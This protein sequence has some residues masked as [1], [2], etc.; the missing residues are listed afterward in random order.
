MS[1][2]ASSGSVDDYLRR[3]ALTLIGKSSAVWEPLSGF[4]GRESKGC[5]YCF[6]WKTHDLFI[7]CL[8]DMYMCVTLYIVE[9]GHALFV[10]LLGGFARLIYRP[11]FSRESSQV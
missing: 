3:H 6:Q 5:V 10:Q 7:L 1:L 11:F 8:T 4:A 9:L 2:V